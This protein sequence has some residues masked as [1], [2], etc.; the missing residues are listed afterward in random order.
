MEPIECHVG[1]VSLGTSAMRR[2]GRG[3]AACLTFT[4]LTVVLPVPQPLPRYTMAPDHFWFSTYTAYCCLTSPTAFAQL[5][6]TVS[7]V[8]LV[9]F[10]SAGHVDPLCVELAECEVGTAFPVGSVQCAKLEMSLFSAIPLVPQPWP[11]AQKG[12]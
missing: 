9:E 2:A 5:H 10:G 3:F 7:D 1:T 4:Q 8:V 11:T 12:A 6:K